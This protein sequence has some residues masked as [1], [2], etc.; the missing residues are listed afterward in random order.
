M[1]PSCSIPCPYF[2]GQPTAAFEMGH[3]EFF[4][5]EREVTLELKCAELGLDTFFL[6]FCQ[7]GLSGMAHSEGK[8]NLALSQPL[9]WHT[10]RQCPQMTYAPEEWFKMHLCPDCAICFTFS[11]I[12]CLLG[13]CGIF[14][15]FQYRL[16]S[17]IKHPNCSSTL[18]SSPNLFP[19]FPDPFPCHFLFE[20]EH[21]SSTKQVYR[22]SVR[23]ILWL[24]RRC[25]P[26]L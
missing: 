15:C 2:K 14:V 25:L 4:T 11:H 17:Y 12:F 6:L 5:V 1:I 24:S 7:C 26:E 18:P 3:S 23:Y 22:S 10:T 19:S 13:F 21:A 20:K 9:M 8:L 16:F